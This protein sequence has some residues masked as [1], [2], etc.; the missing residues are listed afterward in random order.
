M[1]PQPESSDT[2]VIADVSR[3]VVDLCLHLTLRDKTILQR[4]S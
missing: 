3:Y 4:P 2:R 1:H